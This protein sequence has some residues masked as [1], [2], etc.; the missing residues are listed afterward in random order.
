MLPALR[1]IL[2]LGDPLSAAARKDDPARF[3]RLASRRDLLVLTALDSPGLDAATLTKDALLA[4]IAARAEAIAAADPVDWLPHV[5]E[6]DGRRR[7]P[8]FSTE[9]HFQAYCEAITRESCRI[10]GF[11]AAAV[12]G[13]HVGNLT[14]D[15]EVLVLNPRTRDEVEIPRSTAEFLRGDDGDSS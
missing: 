11:Q 2:G 13:S 12:P 14:T 5:E 7:V 9:E 6:L 1:R 15:D 4:E 8:V 3:V 10:H